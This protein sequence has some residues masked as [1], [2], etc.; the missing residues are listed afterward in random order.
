[1]T[2]S[3]TYTLYVTPANLMLGNGAVDSNITYSADDFGVTA[4]TDIVV[5]SKPVTG[6][7]TVGAAAV[8]INLSLVGQTARYT[9]T[10]TGSQNNLKFYSTNVTFNQSGCQA[11][12]ALYFPG[13]ASTRTYEGMLSSSTTSS[14][15]IYP[16]SSGNANI[17]NFIPLSQAG[18]YTIEIATQTGCT[19]SLSGRVGT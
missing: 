5:I 10:G 2:S 9:F 11:A 19:V 16:S 6:T 7:F 3:G 12:I 17:I 4:G 8:P 14:P 1:V 13:Q 18:T 15:I